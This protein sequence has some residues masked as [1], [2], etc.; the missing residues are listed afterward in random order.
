LRVVSTWDG[1]LLES[2]PDGNAQL[3]NVQIAATE[4]SILSSQRGGFMFR[5]LYEGSNKW[6]STKISDPNRARPVG[7]IKFLPRGGKAG[8]RGLTYA[9][10]LGTIM[11]ED[12]AGVRQFKNAGIV[13]DFN[14]LKRGLQLV[15]CGTDNPHERIRNGT[16]RFW[17]AKTQQC[18][19]CWSTTDEAEQPP[20]YLA[21]SPNEL[22]I[23]TAH[24]R[25]LRVWSLTGKC[26]Q[27]LENP[28]PIETIVM[29]DD[30]NVIYSGAGTGKHRDTIHTL[31]L[32]PIMPAMDF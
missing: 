8:L 6:S 21:I 7:V 19:R 20:E 2:L 31:S 18:V 1:R 29:L 28:V 16:V 27:R 13:Y 17:D 30:W 25:S 4:A 22:R 32:T 11:Q 26:V 10:E 9:T 24:G 23:V 14:V 15:S 5:H 12:G 3:D